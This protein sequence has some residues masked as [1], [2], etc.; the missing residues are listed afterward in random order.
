MEPDL[1]TRPA[2][3][4]T[5]SVRR[6]E[7]ELLGQAI[8][9]YFFWPPRAGPIAGPWE[10]TPGYVS[11]LR[12][13]YTSLMPTLQGRWSVE[14]R[15]GGA[16]VRNRA[17]T[18]SDTRGS[19]DTEYTPCCTSLTE[20]LGRSLPLGRTPAALHFGLEHHVA[21]RRSC[22]RTSRLARPRH[23]PEWRHPAQ[24]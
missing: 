15:G 2:A 24:V 21:I 4:C 3:V 1:S 11:L 23:G 8:S 22:I 10:Q 20:G 5:R 14:S 7:K 19:F 17:R 9:F 18:H 6:P 16:H 12:D 13:P